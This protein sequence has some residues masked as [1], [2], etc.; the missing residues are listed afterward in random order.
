MN[1]T[2][3]HQLA[4]K[5][6]RIVLHDSI[7]EV[8]FTKADGTKRLLIGTTSDRVVPKGLQGYYDEERTADTSRVNVFDIEK[9][10]W[11]SFLAERV[12]DFKIVRDFSPAEGVE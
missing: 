1:Q 10:E 11:R 6:Y 5:S 7:A 12:L 8:T 9:N 3:L 4:A 2:E